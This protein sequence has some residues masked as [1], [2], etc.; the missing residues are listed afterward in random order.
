MMNRL[1]DK[2]NQDSWG[3]GDLNFCQK[4]KDVTFKAGMNNLLYDY[5]MF[6]LKGSR[7]FVLSLVI[8]IWHGTLR[9]E[10]C[11]HYKKLMGE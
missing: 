4:L 9:M 8:G 3:Y 11:L 10:T 7:S 2:G 1:S 6:F 5:G